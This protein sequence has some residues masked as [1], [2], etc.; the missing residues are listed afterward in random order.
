M[1]L[2]L[3]WRRDCARCPPAKAI[4][5]RLEGDGFIVE[6]FDTDTVDGMAEAAFY[7]VAST[8]TAIA[9]D[10]GGNEVM[11]WRGEVPDAERAM[12]VLRGE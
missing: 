10:E 2:K 5:T 12:R 6:Y 9:V 3:F 8:P 11:S 4:C 7:E 1:K